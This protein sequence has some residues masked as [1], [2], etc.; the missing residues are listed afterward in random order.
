M[1][2]AM[3]IRE[4]TSA[5]KQA[6]ADADQHELQANISAKRGGDPIAHR[7]EARIHRAT[8]QAFWRAANGHEGKR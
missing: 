2:H 3:T 8:A 5:R 4:M 1:R 6:S 7:V